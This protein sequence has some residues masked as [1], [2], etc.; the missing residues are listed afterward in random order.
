MKSL[1]NHSILLMCPT[2]AS[3]DFSNCNILKLAVWESKYFAR[4][5]S[6]R[7]WAIVACYLV[8]CGISES[9]ITD[10]KR[11]CLVHIYIEF[12]VKI[13]FTDFS[14]FQIIVR[15]WLQIIASILIINEN[16]CCFSI[17]CSRLEFIIYSMSWVDR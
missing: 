3:A 17:K 13:I 11:C 16:T 10:C 12:L 6:R 1:G 2:W 5:D 9:Y 4:T 7:G 15:M 8:L 14:S